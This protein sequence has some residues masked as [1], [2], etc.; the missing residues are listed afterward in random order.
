MQNKVWDVLRSPRV[1]FIIGGMLLFSLFAFHLFFVHQNLTTTFDDA[2][3]FLRYAE[4]AL[5]GHGIAWNPDGVQTYGATSLLYLGLVIV[6][7]GLFPFADASAILVVTSCVLGLA[8]LTLMVL[9]LGRV[10]VSDFFRKNFFI[11]PVFMA[12]LFFLSPDYLFH[13]TSGMDTTLAMLCNTLVIFAALNWVGRENTASLLMLIAAAYASFLARP[14]DLIYAV[15]F[16]ALYGLFFLREN[17]VKK[18]FQFGMGLAAVLAIDTAV[19][20][21]VFGDPLPLPFYAKT[22]GYDDGYTGAGRWNPVAYLFD[23]LGL[24]FPFIFIAMISVSRHTR[25]LAAAFFIPVLVTFTYFF[26]VTQ[27]MGFGARYYFP[28]VPFF[29][30]GAWMLF[31]RRLEQVRPAVVFRSPLR[32][33]ATVV[34]ASILFLPPVGAL[35]EAA[36]ERTF[37]ATLRVYESGFAQ[38]FETEL[39]ELGWWQSIDAV[40]AICEKLPAGTKV[41]LSEYGLVGARCVHIHIIDPLGL[42]D[43]FFAHNGFSSTEFFNREPDLIWFPHPDYA[44]I[45]SSIQDDLRFQTNYEY[46]PGAFDYGI[47]IRKDAEAYD[48][49]LM[50]VQRV[51]EETYPGLGLGDFRF[52]PP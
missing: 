27:I 3:M 28:S 43:P 45:I 4:N 22:A 39:P 50:S 16:P 52:H 15:V 34:A 24:M 46:Y 31:D 41:G 44:D 21:V 1:R 36:Y 32:I 49:I 11:L 17:R 33:A 47:A 35:L 23:F 6:G 40:S 7:R 18:V 8:A 14:D 5:A 25:R 20:Y 42:H 19:K 26:S 30:I 38:D 2:Y 29:V 51:W 48:D 9:V 10:A 12:V 13:A 37:I